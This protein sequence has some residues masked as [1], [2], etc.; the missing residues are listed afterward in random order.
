[1]LFAGPTDQLR[2]SRSTQDYS[3]ET[4]WYTGNEEGEQDLYELGQPAES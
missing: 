2:V 4:L 3:Q 1:M